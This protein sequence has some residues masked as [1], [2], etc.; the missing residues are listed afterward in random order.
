M[1]CL[2][3]ASDSYLTSSYLA[4]RLFA[5]TYFLLIGGVSA[6]R[7][8]A[9]HANPMRYAGLVRRAHTKMHW[10]TLPSA[11]RASYAPRMIC[12]RRAPS[13]NTQWTLTCPSRLQLISWMQMAFDT[14][15]N[16]FIKSWLSIFALLRPIFVM[17]QNFSL[18]SCFLRLLS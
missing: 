10:P 7:L 8:N 15:R 3:S 5:E 6:D 4:S 16:L 17:I 11:P 12:M 14:Y 9:P 2:S 1:A 13:V 18:F